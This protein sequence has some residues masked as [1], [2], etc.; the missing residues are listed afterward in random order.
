MVVAAGVLSVVTAAQQAP[1]GVLILKSS[2]RVV[3]EAARSCVEGCSHVGKI[4]EQMDL[5]LKKK[6]ASKLEKKKV[7]LSVF[8]D[9]V[10]FVI[11]RK[12]QKCYQKKNKKQQ[13]PARTN[14]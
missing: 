9:D 11:H 2:S 13:Q 7:K 4:R 1:L 14:Q 8:S 3:G 5:E 10:L 6:K 12:P